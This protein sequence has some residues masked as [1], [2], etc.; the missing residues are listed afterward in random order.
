M[1][2]YESIENHQTLNKL[3]E[4]QHALKEQ[5]LL[6]N[7]QRELAQIELNKIVTNNSSN[8]TSFSA[9]NEIGSSSNNRSSPNL[10]PIP[11]E[12]LFPCVSFFA[13]F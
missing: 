3:K 6:L 7:K 13:K 1:Q 2:H 12:A 11:L 10:S 8:I 4:D 5:I 9:L